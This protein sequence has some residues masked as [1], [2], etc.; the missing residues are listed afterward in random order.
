MTC[1]FA[2]SASWQLALAG[3]GA[4]VGRIATGRRGRLATSLVSAV[5]IAGLALH[6]M[7]G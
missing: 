1:A 5:V 4:T 7:L 6:T 2:A 3:S